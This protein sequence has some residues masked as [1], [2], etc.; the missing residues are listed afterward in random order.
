[1]HRKGEAFNVDLS[2]P[3]KVTEAVITTG[4]VSIDWLEDGAG[5]HLE[6]ASKDK[7][8]TYKGNFGDPVLNPRWF[9]EFRRYDCNDGSLVLLGRWWQQDNGNEDGFLVRLGPEAKK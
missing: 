3:L 4:R 7:G 2:E 1:M 5:F 9:V 8:R 6:A